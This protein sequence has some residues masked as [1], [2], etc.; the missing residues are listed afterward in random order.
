MDNKHPLIQS[1]AH[2]GLYGVAALISIVAAAA[3]VSLAEGVSPW[4]PSSGA[5]PMNLAEPMFWL[6]MIGGLV[7]LGLTARKNTPA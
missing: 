2:F 1:P 7:G 4:L 6:L 5:A 3:L